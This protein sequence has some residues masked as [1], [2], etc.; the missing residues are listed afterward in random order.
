MPKWDNL[1]WKKPTNTPKGPSTQVE[2]EKR[3]LQV[4]KLLIQWYARYEIVSL[5]SREYNVSSTTVDEYIKKATDRIRVKNNESLEDKIDI[6]EAQI[7]DWYQVSMREKKRADAARFLKLKMELRG[8]EAP[9]KIQMSWGMTIK[10]SQLTK[11]WDTGL[12][13]EEKAL[14]RDITG[15]KEKD[16]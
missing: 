2:V 4:S 14:A 15:L 3:V 13:D 16:K 1:R 8:L 10:E 5:V 9:K 12:T 6:T 7:M 11:F